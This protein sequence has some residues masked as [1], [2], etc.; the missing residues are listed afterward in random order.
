[1]FGSN[2]TV[3]LSSRSA[4]DHHHSLETSGN[5]A[6]PGDCGGAFQERVRRPKIGSDLIGSSPLWRRFMT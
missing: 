4:S 1:M 5:R 6:P 3:A 2:G